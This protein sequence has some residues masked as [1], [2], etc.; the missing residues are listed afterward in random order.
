MN[1]LEARVIGRVQGV[2]F[3]HYTVEQARAL[4]LNGWVA[5]APDG[6]VRVVAEG[7]VPDLKRLL[8]WLHTGP[9]M[10]HVDAVYADWSESTGE[11]H[12]FSVRS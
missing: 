10:A 1:R 5:N 4:G 7:P 9:A 3:R 6:S 2:Y 12:S 11:F 8:L